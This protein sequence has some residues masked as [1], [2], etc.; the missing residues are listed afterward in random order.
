MIAVICPDSA[1]AE[2]V[3]QV[4][5][6]RRRVAHVWN[7][8]WTSA[9]DA[10]AIVATALQH[11]PEI[12]IIGP[13][14]AVDIALA[15]VSQLDRGHPEI[16]KILVAA[17]EPQVLMDAMRAGVREVLAPASGATEVA[18]A[19][20]RVDGATSRLRVASP[21]AESSRP[22]N[23]VI[24]VLSAKGGTGKSVVATNLAYGLGV[25]TENQ[26]VLVD[27]DI[28]FGD[29]ANALNLEP[30]QTLADAAMASA[31]L[32][33]TTLKVFLTPHPA[34]FYVLCAP[35]SLADAA[36][37]TP[38]QVKSVLSILSLTF[39]Y[40]VVDTSPGID[41][42]S[43]TALEFSTD[44]VLVCSSEV[45][46]VRA[47]RRQVETLDM[48]GMTNQQRHFVVNRA[49]TRVGLRTSDI[50]ETVGLEAEVEIPSSRS[51]V[52]SMNQGTPILEGASRDAAA[53]ALQD[54]VKKFLPSDDGGRRGRKGK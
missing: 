5:E 20:E 14:F 49:G 7:M 15:V 39:D 1:Y 48:V 18:A 53:R 41:D 4:L 2:Y 30:E 36:E 13:G 9:D 22:T 24:T 46:S 52:L 6:A 23:R 26:T 21:E 8:A 12:V 37:I 44:M 33:A 16:G 54:L 10:E 27:L 43:L 32:D 51:V 19:I 42:Q 31:S 47:M 28:H 17:P 50:E 25:A 34:G 40:V 35:T 11:R 38:E 3:E 45:P 29:C